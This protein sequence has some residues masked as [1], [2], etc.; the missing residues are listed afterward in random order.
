MRFETFGPFPIE[1]NEYGNLPR[2]MRSFWNDIEKGDEGLSHARGCYV[3][4]IKSSGGPSIFPWY[5]GRTHLQGFRKECF[6]SHQRSLYLEAIN[7]YDRAV[8]Y[9]YIAAQITMQDRFYQGKSG[10]SIAFL[11]TYLISLGLQV[12]KN[13]LNKQSTKMYREV[14]MPGILNSSLGN[15]GRPAMELRQTF[16]F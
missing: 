9:L 5:I 2:R 7:R 8:P 10:A 12:N 11:E 3:F 4:G 6:G 1:L 16:R 14:I 13:L 15:P